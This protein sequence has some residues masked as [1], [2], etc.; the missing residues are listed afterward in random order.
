MKCWMTGQVRS[1]PPVET[2]QACRGQ[3]WDVPIGLKKALRG[4]CKTFFSPTS[5]TVLPPNTV[6]VAAM[7]RP[8]CA[9]H[10]QDAGTMTTRQFSP[11]PFSAFLRRLTRCHAP[12]TC[13]TQMVNLTLQQ[14]DRA[15]GEPLHSSAS[16]MTRLVMPLVTTTR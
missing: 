2:G 16:A 14:A 7:L 15:A 6:H 3:A 1:V 8:G 9:G 13:H 11:E 4:L 5:N 12:A 10:D